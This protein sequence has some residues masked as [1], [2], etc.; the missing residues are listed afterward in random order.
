[1][2]APCMFNVT[3]P[4]AMR[5]NGVSMALTSSVCVLLA[6]RYDRMPGRH[7]KPKGQAR[8]GWMDNRDQQ[9]KILDAVKS[10]PHAV[11]RGDDGEITKVD[12]DDVY[13]PVNAARKC[14]ICNTITKKGKGHKVCNIPLSPIVFS[15]K[16]FG[17]PAVRPFYGMAKHWLEY[18][19]RYA[20]NR[21][22]RYTPYYRAK[23]GFNVRFGAEG[24]EPVLIDV[25]D[26]ARFKKVT[27]DVFARDVTLHHNSD[28]VFHHV[29][30]GVKEKNTQRNTY[31]IAETIKKKVWYE[32][33]NSPPLEEQDYMT[34]PRAYHRDENAIALVKWFG[35][36]RFKEAYRHKDLPP[37]I[38]A[39][40]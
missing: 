19:K 37:V 38:H 10:T 8:D 17:K 35:E 33:S 13:W 22:L 18:V 14:G 24:E 11:V 26:L 40:D 28:Y 29:G 36:P 2:L 20:A 4:L 3:N 32:R 31:P 25:A 23:G 9:L 27:K 39:R 5:Y 6:G 12:I 21:D 30:E 1:M 15:R 16:E 7:I 34:D